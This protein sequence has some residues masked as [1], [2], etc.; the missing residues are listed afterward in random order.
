MERM[1]DSWRA[2]EHLP[3]PSVQNGGGGGGGQGG[4][5]ARAAEKRYLNFECFKAFLYVIFQID[6]K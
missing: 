6:A 5:N 3:F 1:D 4:P 2:Q